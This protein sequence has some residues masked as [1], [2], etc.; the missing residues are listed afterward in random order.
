MLG[1]LPVQVTYGTQSKDLSLV[2]VQGSGLAL[3][4]RDWLGHIKLDWPVITYH[5]VDQLKLEETLQRYHEVFRE[6]LG[7]AKTPA[8][9][10]TV[11]DQSQ[12]KFM[13]AH[14]V[15][16]AIKEAI[17]REIDQLEDIGVLEK[18]EFSRWRHQ[19]CQSPR[20]MGP[21]GYVGT[22]RSL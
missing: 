18:V 22:T 21:S 1:A 14:L 2:I 15:P 17:G 20:Q 8:V 9:S 6:E 10:L 13:H 19:L 5:T 7:T 12:P 4:V 11:K 16:F 3:L